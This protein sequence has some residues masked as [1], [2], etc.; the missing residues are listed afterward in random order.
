M[1]LMDMLKEKINIPIVGKESLEEIKQVWSAQTIKDLLNGSLIISYDLINKQLAEHSISPSVNDIV[2]SPVEDN[3]LN[4]KFKHEQYGAISCT[5]EI[6]AF[7]HNDKE[8]YLSFKIK[9]KEIKGKNIIS[10]IIADIGYFIFTKL[11]G[12]FPKFSDEINVS[13]TDDILKVDFREY[14]LQSNFNI[15][16]MDKDII[17]LV[18]VLSLEP[19]AEG[20]KVNTNLKVSPVIRKMMEMIIK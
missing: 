14:L 18:D 10:K 8:S 3:L 7:K 12:K 15:K 6:I 9:E 1:S 11:L 13:M 4:I 19:N 5:G 2:I 17:N 16:I 20:I